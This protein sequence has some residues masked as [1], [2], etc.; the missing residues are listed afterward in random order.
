[1][2]GG[3]KSVRKVSVVAYFKLLSEYSPEKSSRKGKEIL[4]KDER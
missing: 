2:N 4:S 3:Y 1:M